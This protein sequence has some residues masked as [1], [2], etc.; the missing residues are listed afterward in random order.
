MSHRFF[1]Y[2]EE[3]WIAQKTFDLVEVK[4]QTLAEAEICSVYA[5]ELESLGLE[6]F[7]R[8]VSDSRFNIYG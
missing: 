5:T 4:S 1:E 2:V 6:I 7:K 3:D 8:K